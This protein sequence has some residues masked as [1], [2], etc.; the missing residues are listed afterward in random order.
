MQSRER[1]RLAVV[2]AFFGFGVVWHLD[3][4]YADVLAETLAFWDR[5]PIL[6]RLEANRVFHLATVHTHMVRT[7]QAQQQVAQQ[8][9][10]LQGLLLQLLG[11]LRGR[12]PVTAAR[13]H[14]HRPR[15]QHRVEG[16]RAPGA[17]R[18][19]LSA[20]LG[21]RSRR[22][23]DARG[24]EPPQGRGDAP[25]PC[26]GDPLDSV[27]VG[28]GVR[29]G[30]QVAGGRQQ[31]GRRRLGLG[32]PRPSLPVLGLGCRAREPPL[33]LLRRPRVGGGPGL[34]RGY[35]SGRTWWCATLRSAL[36]TLRPAARAGWQMSKS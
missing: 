9:E 14:R 28:P 8:A 36:T 17:S 11:L 19:G 18:S 21:P 30:L 24:V 12:A 31:P 25:A 33:P 5:N 16:R 3:T 20:G 6:Q 15:P 7:V 32:A 23:S 10:V 27:F 29:V 34:G 26:P 4:P 22:A 2:P 1:L 13:P 35:Q